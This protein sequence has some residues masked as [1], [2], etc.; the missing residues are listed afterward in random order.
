MV[1][2]IHF[3]LKVT[4][5]RISHRNYFIYLKRIWENIGKI[6][7]NDVLSDVEYIKVYGL[8]LL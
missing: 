1:L 7:L 8:H 5:R 3:D 2:F 6:A 4:Y